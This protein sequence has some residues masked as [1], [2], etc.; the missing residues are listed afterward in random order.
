MPTKFSGISSST[1]GRPILLR[2]RMVRFL[3]SFLRCG[4]P[5]PSKEDFQ[6]LR[7]EIRLN[8]RL[9]QMRLDYLF[10]LG[11]LSTR[12]KK[13]FLSRLFRFLSL[14][15]PRGV[16]GHG[17][18][19]FGPDG[20]AGYVLLD[21]LE[22]ITSVLSLGVGKNNDVDYF[23]AS[24]LGKQVFAYDHT[25]SGLPKAHPKIL[26]RKEGIGQGPNLVPLRVVASSDLLGHD[27]LLMCDIEGSEF[28]T[29]FYDGVDFSIFKQ[30][31]I[32]THGLH[33]KLIDSSDS[34]LFNLLDCLVAS[35]QVTHLH[36]NN[37]DPV[38]QFGSLPLPE[39]L[40]I[41]LVRRK[42]YSFGTFVGE[43]PRDYDSPNSTLLE[44]PAWSIPIALFH[45]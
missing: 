19:K 40:E 4:A 1:M 37:Y 14:V 9:M 12:E 7:A 26:F 18:A 5:T 11:V 2:S 28:S 44:E 3:A 41:T 15:L 36:A 45:S 17:M 42:D 39:T 21:D 29:A 13:E 16:S 34:S 8:N 27:A 38:S 30:I 32:E 10:Q 35:H 25:V 33:R 6:K 31:S 22:K 24:V 43:F 20:D 23:F